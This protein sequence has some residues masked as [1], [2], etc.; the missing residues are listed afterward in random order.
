LATVKAGA[1]VMSTRKVTLYA[2]EMSEPISISKVDNRYFFID[3]GFGYNA[4][5]TLLSIKQKVFLYIL[6]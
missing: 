5:I 4:K 3:K 2:N 6:Q 1:L